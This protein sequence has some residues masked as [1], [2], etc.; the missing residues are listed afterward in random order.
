MSLAEEHSEIAWR[1]T[2]LFA[3]PRPRER[4]LSRKRRAFL[5]EGLIHRTERGDLVRSKSELVMI[6]DKPHA[7]GINYVYEQPLVLADGRVRYPDFNHS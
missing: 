6:A 3:D 1:M 4:S 7:R 2:N 5:E